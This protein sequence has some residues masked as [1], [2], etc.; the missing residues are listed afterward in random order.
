MSVSPHRLDFRSPH[1]LLYIGMVG[2]LLFWLLRPSIDLYSG[3]EITS[4]RPQA[5]ERF[6]DVLHRLGVETDT[7]VWMSQRYQRNVFYQTLKDS[8]GEGSS[9]QPDR[10]NK[11]GIPLTGWRVQAGPVYTVGAIS[12]NPNA[13]LSENQ[14]VR[15]DFDER[16]RIRFLDVRDPVAAFVPGDS[17]DAIGRQVLT[18]ILG[19]DAAFYRLDSLPAFGGDVR[20]AEGDRPSGT[21][22]WVRTTASSAGPMY[23]DLVVEPAVREAVGDS[24][25][26]IRQGLRLRSATAVYHELEQSLPAQ[27]GVPDE[28]YYLLVTLAIL[29]GVVLVAGFIQIYR[30]QV[31]WYRGV[32]LFLMMFAA[33]FG[34]RYVTFS[35]TYY[36]L[37]SSDMVMIDLIGQGIYYFI[38]A[39][40]GAVAYVTWES[41]ARINQDPQ[42]GTVDAIWGGRLWNRQIGRS[43]IAGV[44]F[45]GMGLALWA[46]ALFGLDI[47]YM[48]WDSQLGFTDISTSWPAL[49]VLM[50]AWT[51]TWLI[52]FPAFGVILSIIQNRVRRSLPVL[53][54][55]PL[56]LGFL[57]IMLGRTSA[58]TGTVSE[59]L[60]PLIAFCVPLVFA[61]RYFGLLSTLTAWWTAYILI[62]LGPYLQASDP[63][64]VTNGLIL[65]AFPVLTLIAGFVLYRFAPEESGRR[66]VPDYEERNLKQMRIEKEFQIA[67][68][69]QFALMPRSAPVVQGAEVKGFFIPSFEV[70]GDY[71]DYQAHGDDLT[72]TIV[73]V[74]GK[75]MK[76][77]F[78]AIFTSGLLLARNATRNPAE[79]LS[80]INPILHQRTDR[81][82]FVTCLLARFDTRTRV[83]RFANAGHCRPM[84]KRAGDIRYLDTDPPRFPLG[85]REKVAYSEATHPL[86]S[87]DLVLFFSDGLPEARHPE[88]GIFDYSGVEELLSSMDTDAMSPEAICEVIRQRI[89]A[90]SAYELADD[91]TVVALKVA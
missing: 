42:M 82:T 56:I 68:E 16:M 6:L 9:V 74:S 46:A 18:D 90:Y 21:L 86:E 24:A 12:S 88:G 2:M 73:D 10:L 34:W 45:S 61:T 85:M 81:Q 91:M 49:T 23:V 3:S 75:A 67:K 13:Y 29:A 57:L 14:P 38:V 17:V 64:L 80:D 87:G 53:A 54:V 28:I 55:S 69:S 20:A 76:A 71:Y 27:A 5:E 83:L 4:S 44:A 79:V 39:I 37:F 62:R 36:R 58:S 31:I 33:L 1:T 47:V 72:V 52:V 89:L 65:A 40:F 11:A 77:A 78:C 25:T 8:S 60:V 32:I 63:F 84:L 48:Q 70:G 41:I 22:R 26:T 30:G 66:Y 15:V 51:N 43:L 35:D 59:D 7:L 50:N 19:Y